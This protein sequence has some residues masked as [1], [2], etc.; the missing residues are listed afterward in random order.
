[1]L[2][3]V[4]KTP[5]LRAL[6]DLNELG[7]NLM[8]KS[9]T[10]PKTTL[11]AAVNLAQQQPLVNPST[12]TLNDLQQIRNNQS[13][14]PTT[15][16]PPTIGGKLGDEAAFTALNSLF[17]ELESIKPGSM[18]P[19]VLYD[20]NNLKIVLHFGRD[21]PQPDIYV[22]VISVT[23]GNTQSSLRNFS[24]QAAVPKVIYV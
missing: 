5:Q 8:E 12:L 23:S 22:V 21:S 17:V 13:S 24:F 10:D 19:F 15:P 7:R 20:K 14:G 11:A 6:D 2:I 18:S 16:T 9:L 1:M 3:E 4:A